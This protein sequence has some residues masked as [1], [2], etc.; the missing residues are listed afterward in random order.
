MMTERTFPILAGSPEAERQR[1][2]YGRTVPWQA[3]EVIRAEALRVHSQS[4]E[5]LAERGGLTWGEIGSLFVLHH[6]RGD[7]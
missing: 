2:V 1:E 3:V 7:G 4:L 5:R 6:T